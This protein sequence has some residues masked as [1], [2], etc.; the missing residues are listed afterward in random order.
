MTIT[1]HAKER[2]AERFKIRAESEIR[3]AVRKLEY[4]FIRSE[5]KGGSEYRTITWKGKYLQGVICK[6]HLVT[7]VMKGWETS[8]FLAKWNPNLKE[9]KDRYRNRRRKTKKH[10][11]AI[12]RG[13]NRTMR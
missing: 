2:L 10:E 1:K 6:D 4:D 13:T 8:Y 3:K 12:Y 9:G 5:T 11:K 7:V